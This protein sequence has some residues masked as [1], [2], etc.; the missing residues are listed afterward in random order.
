M[1]EENTYREL[2]HC[3]P[4]LLN[5]H[6]LKSLEACG[7]IKTFVAVLAMNTDDYM[8]RYNSFRTINIFNQGKTL[9]YEN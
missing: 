4:E 3:V 6:T 7:L 8:S 9:Y 5:G 1:V 2:E